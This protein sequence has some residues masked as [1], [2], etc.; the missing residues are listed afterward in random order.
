VSYR[1]AP[2]IKT[3][4]GLTRKNDTAKSSARPQRTANMGKKPDLRT[5]KK[6][7]KP[8]P[9]KKEEKKEDNKV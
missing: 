4:R 5:N 8:K 3:A 1:P 6:D 2:H 7:E 9:I